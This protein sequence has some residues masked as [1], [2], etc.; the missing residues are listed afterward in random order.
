MTSILEQQRV[1]FVGLC[2]QGGPMAA[3]IAEAGLLLHAWAITRLSGDSWSAELHAVAY[4]W[5]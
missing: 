2:D 1:G 4:D 3:A 5:E